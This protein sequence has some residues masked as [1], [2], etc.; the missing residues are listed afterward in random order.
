MKTLMLLSSHNFVLLDVDLYVY[1]QEDEA[2]ENN[3]LIELIN[4]NII[5]C[6]MVNTKD[7]INAE[8]LASSLLLSRLAALAGAAKA[9]P[10][11]IKKIAPTV[12]NECASFIA[13]SPG[14]FPAFQ[15]CTLHATLKSWGSVQQ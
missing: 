14:P 10:C 8:I 4:H 1:G 9:D 2:G 5:S 6:M 7:N 13:L 3:L 15:C 11:F 12:K